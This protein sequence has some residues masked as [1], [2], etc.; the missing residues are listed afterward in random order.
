MYNNGGKLPETNIPN[1][2]RTNELDEIMVNNNLKELILLQIFDHRDKQMKNLHWGLLNNLTIYRKNKKIPNKETGIVMK[3][4]WAM[5]ILRVFTWTLKEG[6]NKII[7]AVIIIIIFNR[8]HT[9]SCNR[10]KVNPPI[11]TN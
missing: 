11:F 9:E 4:H 5:K 7:I 10:H 3:I 8:V 6:R 1:I 2:L